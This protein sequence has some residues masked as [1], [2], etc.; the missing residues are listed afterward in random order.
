MGSSEEAGEYSQ[1]RASQNKRRNDYFFLFLFSND[2]I[3]CM[4]ISAIVGFFF[5]PNLYSLRGVG[6][7]V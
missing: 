4:I 3:G 5:L 7:N 6:K 1:A 2:R